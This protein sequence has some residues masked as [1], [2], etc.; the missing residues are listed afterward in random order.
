MMVRKYFYVSI[1]KIKKKRETTASFTLTLWETFVELSHRIC[2]DE[3]D[4]IKMDT[5]M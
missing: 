5:F 1:L 4:M 3:T 2:L